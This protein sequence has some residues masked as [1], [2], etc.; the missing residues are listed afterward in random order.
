M[1]S[2]EFFPGVPEKSALP[3]GH[4]RVSDQINMAFIHPILVFKQRIE[5]ST[6]SDNPEILIPIPIQQ[7]FVNSFTEKGQ[8][9][10][11]MLPNIYNHSIFGREFLKVADG[12]NL[13]APIG[14]Y[15]IDFARRLISAAYTLRRAALDE[16]NST[17]I[18]QETKILER[19]RVSI[20][21]NA[22]PNSEINDIGS[23]AP[24]TE[25]VQS[26]LFAAGLLTDKKI[27]GFD[28]PIDLLDALTRQGIFSKFS[29]IIPSTITARMGN[30]GWTFTSPPIEHSD[31]NLGISRMLV[32]HYTG[33]DR[34]KYRDLATPA[35]QLLDRRGCP[36]GRILPSYDVSA[37]DIEAQML[38]STMRQ[39][40][41]KKISFQAE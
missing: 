35:S 22:N 13:A 16:Q 14:E 5:S 27:K 6:E 36:V 33:E 28:D 39:Q 3:Q 25:G 2:G 19:E 20:Y 17:N 9:L 4:P 24:F 8:E 10:L 37:V 40:R 7:H 38:T 26:V 11:D 31:R 23:L 1:N 21:Q 32:E 30:R 18:I 34:E 41:G 29:L 15:G 12:I